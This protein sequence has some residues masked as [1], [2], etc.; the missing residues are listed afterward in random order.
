MFR[1]LQATDS[2]Q[3]AIVREEDTLMLNDLQ[4]LLELRK[5]INSFID[6]LQPDAELDTQDLTPDDELITSVS[7]I[8]LAAERGITLPSRSLRSALERGN[9]PGAEQRGYRWTMPRRAFLDWLAGY[10]GS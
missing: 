3:L 5:R 6:T 8:G 10:R 4:E 1:I 9:I 2:P 7:A